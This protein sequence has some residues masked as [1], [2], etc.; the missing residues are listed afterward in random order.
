PTGAE[1][2]N[3]LVSSERQKVNGTLARLDL[4]KLGGSFVDFRLRVVRQDFNYDEYF[5]RG[6]GVLPPTPTA[7]PPVSPIGTPTPTP[8]G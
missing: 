3:S 6:V 5:V 1:S 2:W 8:L 7:A 4:S